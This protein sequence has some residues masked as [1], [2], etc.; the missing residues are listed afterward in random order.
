MSNQ[1]ES[2]KVDYSINENFVDDRL[3]EVDILVMHDGINRNYSSFTKE[4]ME[5]AK[6]T[7]KNVP[8]LAYI[9]KDQYNDVDF[10]GHDMEVVLKENKDGEMEFKIHYLE[11]PI[12]VIPEAND[13]HYEERDGKTYVA[14]KGYLW[15]EYLGE[16]LEIL[17]DNP[18]KSVSMEILVDSGFYND[19]DD[20]FE[21]SKFRYLGVT[22]LGDNVSP[23]MAGAKLNVVKQFSAKEDVDFLK[24]VSELNKDLFAIKPVSFEGGG[25]LDKTENTEVIT[26]EFEEE[27]IE[28]EIEAEEEFIEE[29]E[30]EVVEEFNQEENSEEVAT[31]ELEFKEL[32]SKYEAL[33]IKYNELLE[34]NKSLQEYKDEKESEILATQKDEVINE[35]SLLLDKEDISAIDEEKANFSLDELK[36]KLAKV[37]AEREL[38]KAKLKAEK[39]KTDDTIIFDNKQKDNKVKKNKFAI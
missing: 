14:C 39:A 23:A 35:Y 21:I 25:N 20:V 19:Q 33:E 31:Y 11:K 28:T 24:K 2:L 26:E 12:G 1:C 13:Y 38:E 10:N 16:G 34:T 6:E 18:E 17:Q 9:K 5:E 4:V 30:T 3:I 22:V 7:L 32:T 36:M 29:V 8:I 27:I 15:R 37:F